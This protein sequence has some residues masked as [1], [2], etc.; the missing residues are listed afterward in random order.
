MLGPDALTGLGVDSVS[1]TLP[2]PRLVPSVS[3]CEWYTPAN[4]S[5]AVRERFGYMRR[6]CL[7]PLVF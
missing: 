7:T 1:G 5:E 2:G 3:E 6:E 4:N